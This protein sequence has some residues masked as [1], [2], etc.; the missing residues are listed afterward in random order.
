MLGKNRVI[1][2]GEKVHVGSGRL[3]VFLY[4]LTSSAGLLSLDFEG[5]DL[6]S[7]AVQE[8]DQTCSCCRY[9]SLLMLSPHP[10]VLLSWSG[11]PSSSSMVWQVIEVSIPSSGRRLLD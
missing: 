4:I 8:M 5:V 9:M 2:P 1:F 11:G 3:A 6:V 10:Q 7:G